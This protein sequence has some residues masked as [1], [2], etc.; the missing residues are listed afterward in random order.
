MSQTNRA[1]KAFE[2]GKWASILE[3]HD[4]YFEAS[5]WL[6]LGINR[7]QVAKDTGGAMGEAAGTANHA[8]KLFTAL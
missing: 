2:G 1:I 3:Y 7:F 5:A 4:K 6:V 8:A